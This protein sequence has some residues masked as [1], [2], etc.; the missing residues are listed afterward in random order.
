MG[1]MYLFKVITQQVKLLPLIKIYYLTIHSPM[2]KKLLQEPELLILLAGN[3]LC[4]W[5]FV[6]DT[7]GFSNII[8]VYWCQRVIIGLFNF[9]DLLTIK[10]YSAKDFK[11]NDAPVTNENKGC[12]AWF[13]LLHYGGFHTAY[14]VFLVVRYHAGIDMSFL[15]LGIGAF[16]LESLLTF[17]RKKII[18][19]E[20]ALNIGHIFFLP[21]LRIIPMH[22]TILVPSFLGW[23]PSLLFVVLKTVADIAFYFIARRIYFKTAV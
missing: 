13:F 18:E 19:R 9:F 1:M 8:W 23:T 11:I 14:F 17:S 5:Y 7:K 12:M 15:L 6:D 10:N 20:K 16:F 4:I 21:Y 3:A 22:L 2:L